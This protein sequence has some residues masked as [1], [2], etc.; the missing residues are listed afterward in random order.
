MIDLEFSSICCN[1]RYVLHGNLLVIWTGGRPCQRL[2][3]WL[4]E[5]SA[6]T[7]FWGYVRWKRARKKDIDTHRHSIISFSHR[8]FL[9]GSTRPGVFA[10]LSGDGIARII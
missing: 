4:Q 3:L 10:H 6:R 5:H 1:L 8:A 9:F 7:A 2:L